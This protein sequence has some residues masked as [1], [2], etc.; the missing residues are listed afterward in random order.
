MSKRKISVKGK[1]YTVYLYPDGKESTRRIAA[2]FDV[3]R[4]SVPMDS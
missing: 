1:I 2:M 3:S 4:V